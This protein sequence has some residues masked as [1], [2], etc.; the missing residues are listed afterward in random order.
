MN[1]QQRQLKTYDKQSDFFGKYGGT[2]VESI[3]SLRPR[4]L[5]LPANG[6]QDTLA[7]RYFRRAGYC[8]H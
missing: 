1:I 2:S 6:I 3:L 4:F 7:L 8:C 5:Q